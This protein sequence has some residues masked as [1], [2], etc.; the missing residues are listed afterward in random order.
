MPRITKTILPKIRKSLRQKGMLRTAWD[1]A[2]GPYQ[3]FRTYR[4]TQKDYRLLDAPSE[5]DRKHNVETSQRVHMTDLRIDSPNW[6]YA[7]GYWPT[8]PGI[9]RDALFGLE[10]RYE[11]FTFIDLGSGKGRVLLLASEYPFRR[12]VGVEFSAELHAIAEE[13][14]R[15]YRSATQKCRN[16]DSCCMDF[17]LFQ[18]PQEPVF[19]FLYNPSSREITLSL[20]NNLAR[21]LREHP[22]PAWVVY[23]TP[24][25]DVFSSGEPLSLRLVKSGKQYALYSNCA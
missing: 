1:C 8:P 2:L 6:I 17:T 19:L 11:D 15:R 24:T 12:I 10:I 3:L 13:N 14:I 18:L 4:Q 20:A 21:S 9:V 7:D 5:F 22:R 23:V 25:Y 16:I